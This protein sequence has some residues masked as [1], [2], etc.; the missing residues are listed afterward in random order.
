MG[1]PSDL[2]LLA[3]KETF[4][5]NQDR[6]PME[7]LLAKTQKLRM[8][9]CTEDDELVPRVWEGLRDAPHLF[10]TMAHKKNAPLEDF[11]QYLQDVQEVEI[12]EQKRRARLDR[13]SKDQ[14]RAELEEH[15]GR[16]ADKGEREH[17][18]H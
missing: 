4:N 16:G 14:R 17:K 18:T 6:T 1:T 5:W 7:Y 11:R 15:S 2:W 12:A 10:L 8:A 3:D 13:K 9:G